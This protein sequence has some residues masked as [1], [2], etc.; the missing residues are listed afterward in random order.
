MMQGRC[1][2]W[3]NSRKG[4]GKEKGKEKRKRKGK[5]KEREIHGK[6]NG[7]LGMLGLWSTHAGLEEK[8]GG[9]SRH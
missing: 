8:D 3:Y 4:E 6:V 5:G 1:E 7:V 9:T 2:V